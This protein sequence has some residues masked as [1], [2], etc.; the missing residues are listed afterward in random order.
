[1]LEKRNE[2]PVTDICKKCPH[3]DDCTTKYTTDEE[4]KEFF[5]NGTE[6]QNG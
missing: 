5:K 2:F 6:A 1:M 3:L 4:V